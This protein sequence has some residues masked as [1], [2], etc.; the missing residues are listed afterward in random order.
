MEK[1]KEK[2]R[3]LDLGREDN[4]RG[5]ERNLF[6][7]NVHHL[8][9]I[10]IDSQSISKGKEKGI[11]PWNRYLKSTLPRDSI[12]LN[13]WWVGIEQYQNVLYVEAN[14][15]TNLVALRE[16]GTGNLEER[17]MEVKIV[18]TGEFSEKNPDGGMSSFNFNVVSVRLSSFFGM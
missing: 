18:V 14:E 16:G 13:K 8:C 10:Q 2:I 9:S 1:R 6:L 15:Q 5:K 4:S 11:V 12:A 17:L 3:W 7:P